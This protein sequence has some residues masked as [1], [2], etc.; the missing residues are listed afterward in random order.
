MRPRSERTCC[1]WS[2]EARLSAAAAKRYERAL[3]SIGASAVSVLQSCPF[4]RRLAAAT[5]SS[6]CRFSGC[7]ASSPA[8]TGPMLAGRPRLLTPTVLIKS[9]AERTLAMGRAPTDV[10][11]AEPARTGETE[12][13]SRARGSRTS[14]IICGNANFRKVAIAVSWQ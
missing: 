13:S 10:C 8:S 12:Q 5:G 14:L 1:N 6:S 9:C 4:E 3:R 7:S 11:A 2:S